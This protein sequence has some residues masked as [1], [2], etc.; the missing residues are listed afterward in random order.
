MLFNLYD[1]KPFHD[2]M[3]DILA[4]IER[5]NDTWDARG[6]ATLRAVPTPQAVSA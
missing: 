1:K 2:R 3:D 6:A 5:R 4:D